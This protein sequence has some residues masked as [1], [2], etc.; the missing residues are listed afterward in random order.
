MK[1]FYKIKCG[2]GF[3][4][5]VLCMNYVDLNNYFVLLIRNS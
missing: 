5:Y 3:D 1:G 4:Y 2:L